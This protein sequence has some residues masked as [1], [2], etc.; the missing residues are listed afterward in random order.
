[1]GGL[2]EKLRVDV[3]IE[4][5]VFLWGRPIPDDPKPCKLPDILNHKHPVSYLLSDL[6]YAKTDRTVT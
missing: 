4:H 3:E 5:A 1:M 6:K 2:E